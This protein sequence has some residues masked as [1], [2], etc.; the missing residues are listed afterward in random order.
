MAPYLLGVNPVLGIVVAQVLDGAAQIQIGDGVFVGVAA[1]VE[2]E[3]ADAGSVEAPRYVLAL[4]GAA[5]H[6]LVGKAA[7]GN[8]D[9]GRIASLHDVRNE[10]GLVIKLVRLKATLDLV[11]VGK[12]VDGPLGVRVLGAHEALKEPH[13][14]NQ[15]VLARLVVHLVQLA[16]A[17]V[18]CHLVPCL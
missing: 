4:A 18:A 17:R 5:V 3:G 10:V 14:G 2:D 16:L 8:H 12:G 6:G 11:H 15:V 7:T 1:V 9:D 13:R